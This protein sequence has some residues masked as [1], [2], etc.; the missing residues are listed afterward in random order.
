M[1]QKRRRPLVSLP[2]FPLSMERAREL[3]DRYGLEA[4]PRQ[5]VRM[6]S[7]RRVVYWKIASHYV[8]TMA[9]LEALL[10]ELDVARRMILQERTETR[11]LQTTNGAGGRR[12]TKGTHGAVTPPPESKSSR[13]S[14]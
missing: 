13:K 14:A 12:R 1:S 3:V 6:L 11:N 10:S 2:L 8:G 4:E 7:G 9:N 5:D